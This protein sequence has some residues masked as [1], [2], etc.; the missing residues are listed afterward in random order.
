MSRGVAIGDY[1]VMAEGATMDRKGS[2]RKGLDGARRQASSI[3][4]HAPRRS[5]IGHAPRSFFF[6]EETPLERLQREL[7]ALTA[8]ADELRAEV[9]PAAPCH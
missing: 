2:H 4:A 1:L 6:L 3:S 5:A 9:G 8:S 7:K